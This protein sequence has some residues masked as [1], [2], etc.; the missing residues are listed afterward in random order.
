MSASVLFSA[1]VT[2]AFLVTSLLL[3][4]YHLW[5][6][7]RGSGSASELL[8]IGV[9]E[10]LAAVTAVAG[11]YAAGYLVRELGLRVAMWPH[12]PLA[13]RR[14]FLV[15]AASAG[16]VTSALLYATS[17]DFTESLEVAS[18]M[19]TG[20]VAGGLFTLVVTGVITAFFTDDHPSA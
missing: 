18:I 2:T 10:G 7:A 14:R 19:A 15:L 12:G 6:G 1:A 5:N 11:V 16:A 9:L 20:L 13:N 4:L 17:P 3:E 8:G